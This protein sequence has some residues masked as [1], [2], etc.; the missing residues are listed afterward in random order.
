MI[1]HLR[2]V[3][4]SLP[5]R[6]LAAASGASNQ[7]VPLRSFCGIGLHVGASAPTGLSRTACSTASGGFGG[8]RDSPVRVEVGSQDNLLRW[9]RLDSGRRLWYEEGAFQ[10][11]P[12]TETTTFRSTRPQHPSLAPVSV[13]LCTRARAP[14]ACTCTSLS[15]GGQLHRASNGPAHSSAR[16][17][18]RWCPCRCLSD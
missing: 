18:C 1:P 13:S 15:W 10:D 6:T 11:E 12:S 2:V 4:Y 7:A 16:D 14:H 17:V 5:I 3:P 9:I 8:S